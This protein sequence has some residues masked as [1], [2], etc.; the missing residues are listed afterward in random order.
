MGEARSMHKGKITGE[1]ISK[2]EMH[3]V[4]KTCENPLDGLAGAK[5]PMAT[6]DPVLKALPAP[7]SVEGIVRVGNTDT[8][9]DAPAKPRA[10][11]T[12]RWERDKEKG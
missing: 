3:G 1:A 6:G 12:T 7:D 4:N 10:P 2:A 8:Y 9:L 11:G 5:F